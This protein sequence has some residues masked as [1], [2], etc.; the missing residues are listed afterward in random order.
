MEEELRI[1]L[2]KAAYSHLHSFL[3]TT[4]E[5]T[6]WEMLTLEEQTDYL[7]FVERMISRLGSNEVQEA[8][9]ESGVN[10][11]YRSWRKVNFW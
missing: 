5:R 8:W 10:P 4:P 7:N 9:F 3:S 6:D 2:A 1:A 11:F